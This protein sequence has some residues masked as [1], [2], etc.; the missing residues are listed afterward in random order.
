MTEPLR[1]I[2][3]VLLATVDAGH[4]ALLQRLVDVRTE[5]H[6]SG[7]T[8][9]TGTVLGTSVCVAIA[10][11]YGMNASPDVLVE[12][13]I[14][15]FE[16]AAVI[17]LGVAGTLSERGIGVGDVVVAKDVRVS[18]G[19]VEP[20]VRDWKAPGRLLESASQLAEIEWWEGP[21]TSAS[22]APCAVHLQPVSSAVST[23]VGPSLSGSPNTAVVDWDGTTSSL[24]RLSDTQPVLAIYGIQHLGHDWTDEPVKALQF[25]AANAALF[26][27]TLATSLTPV[28]GFARRR[29]HTMG[30]GD[31]VAHTDLLARHAFV[32]SLAELLS[33]PAPAEAEEDLAGPTVI[34]IEGAWGAGK[35]TLMSMTRD[36]LAAA[37]VPRAT[38]GFTVRWRRRR[39]RVWEADCALNGWFTRSAR[40]HD[41]TGGPVLTAEFNPWSCQTGEHI[42][43][44]LNEAIVS[45][46]VSGDVNSVR[47]FWFVHNVER[48]DRRHVQRMLRRRIVSPLLRLAVFALP[49]P[50]LAQL[51]RTTTP[52]SVLGFTVQPVDLALWITGLLLAAG[53]LHTVARYLFRG[54]DVVLAAE[55]FGPSGV[56]GSSSAAA[57]TDDPLRDPRRRARTGLL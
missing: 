21:L 13:A 52:Y 4:T 36:R 15:R 45:A 3:T 27:L 24:C 57:G 35:S 50:L 10:A 25:A 56:L 19:T 12:R 51:L 37:A 48:L 39:L 9:H 29:L 49:V 34:A 41:A 23:P 8:F 54:A 44:G 16:P 6:P 26:A 55:L 47:R 11:A 32:E 28:G 18:G 40:R 17:V 5:T 1:E 22:G 14:E 7:A 53:L 38:R 33:A 20:D 2:N 30:H 31:R 43:A 42:W 46:V